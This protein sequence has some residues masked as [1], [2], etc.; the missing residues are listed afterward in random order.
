MHI[1]VELHGI[2]HSKRL[3]LNWFHSFLL[4]FI[5][6]N[7]C[8]ILTF[9]PAKHDIPKTAKVHIPLAW[10]S[11]ADKMGLGKILRYSNRLMHRKRVTCELH[12]SYF[13]LM[14]IKLAIPKILSGQWNY[15]ITQWKQE[16]WRPDPLVTRC[17]R[18]SLHPASWEA[19]E[20]GKETLMAMR[21]GVNMLQFCSVSNSLSHTNLSNKVRGI[22]FL[23]KS[24]LVFIIA[25]LCSAWICIWLYNIRW[26][27]SM[28]FCD[29]L[30]PFIPINHCYW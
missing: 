22:F 4:F 20:S 5:I 15:Y 3:R 2:L 12:D 13:R 17:G 9:D 16:V 8:C 18:G 28:D 27:I 1:I 19:L 14:M 10:S 6:I 21:V 7:K 26:V 24:L 23:K 25:L 30:L 29:S 11:L